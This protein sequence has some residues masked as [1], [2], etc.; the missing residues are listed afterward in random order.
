[1]AIYNIT[2]YLDGGVNHLSNP[3]TFDSALDLPLTLEDPTKEGYTFDG[4]YRDPDFIN[5]PDSTIDEA[6]DE[7]FYAKWSINSYTLE[8]TDHDGTVLQT[9]DY[10]FGAD[11]S[12]VTAP[13]DPT[14]TGYTFDSWDASIPATMPASNTTI[15]ATYTVNT[16]TLEYQDHDGSILQTGTFEFDADTSSS[17]PA[18][19]TRTGYT[20]DS[21]DAVPATMPASDTV[22]TAVYTINQYTITFD[23]NGGSA[24]AAITQDYG[25]AVTEPA[26]PTKANLT[27]DQWFEDAGL[28]TPYVFDTMPAENITVYAQ[29]QATVTFDS[30]GGT[31]VDS[32]IV[33]ENNAADEPTAP[34]REGYTF[35]AWYTDDG[36]FLNAYTF[37]VDSITE[38]TTLYANWTVNTYTLQFLDHDD[39]VLQTS[40]HEFGAD[41]SAVTA[42][43]DPTRTGYTFDSWDASIPATMLAGD[44]TITAEYIIN[45]YTVTFDSNE[46][47]AVDPISGDY[48]EAEVEPEEPTRDGYTFNGWYEDDGAFTTEYTFDTFD[49]DITLYAEWVLNTYDITYVNLLGSTNDVNPATYDEE[50]A[51]IT[52]VAPTDTE[53]NVFVGWFTDPV[54]GTQV[55]SIDPSTETARNITLYARWS[56][57]GDFVSLPIYEDAN[58]HS[59]KVNKNLIVEVKPARY[60]NNNYYINVTITPG[61]LIRLRELYLT[62][63]AAVLAV[64]ALLDRLANRPITVDGGEL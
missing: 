9:A 25:T 8:F 26:D 22:V 48:G 57:I 15:Q 51:E 21:W 56:R 32:Q 17:A 34:T 29:W 52:L 23:S 20:F 24:V 30:N 5:G 1:M 27:F 45:T 18:D 63:E 43:A 12:A 35:D 31:S 33:S 58:N 16:Y 54:K 39:S 6:G 62:Y 38:D 47:S 59:Y 50:D 42:P 2:Y 14:R 36:T 7:V 61:T 13:A 4:W 49:Q 19:P 28:T 10:E 60:G 46:G 40:D 3:D 55:L 11:L 64:D 44:I 53:D 41:L 37:G